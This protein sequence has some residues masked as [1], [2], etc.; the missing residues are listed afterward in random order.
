MLRLAMAACVV[1]CMFSA[2]V[3]VSVQNGC[4]P[5]YILYMQRRDN[6]R[7]VVIAI[8]LSPLCLYRTYN[9]CFNQTLTLIFKNL[10]SC[11]FCT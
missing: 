6:D 2:V 4:G 1:Q 11:T 8:Q 7:L 3:F 5:V 9:I 10:H